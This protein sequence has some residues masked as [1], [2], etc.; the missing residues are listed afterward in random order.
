MPGKT[1]PSSRA[2]RAG[3]LSPT[4]GSTIALARGR[5]GEITRESRATGAVTGAAGQVDRRT[6]PRSMSLLSGLTG[7]VRRPHGT[8]R[9]GFPEGYRIGRSGGGGRGPGGEDEALL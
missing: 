5:G 1:R 7:P 2:R 8:G 3:P 4:R 9:Q 6:R